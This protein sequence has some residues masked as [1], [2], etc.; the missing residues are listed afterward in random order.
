MNSRGDRRRGE[1]GIRA[2]RLLYVKCETK[3]RH[4]LKVRGLFSA[5]DYNNNNFYQGC[6]PG[7]GSHSSSPS[8]LQVYIS[9]YDLRVVHQYLVHRRIIA[10]V[11]RPRNDDYGREVA[12]DGMSDLRR[13]RVND[14][15]SY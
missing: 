15:L 8:H 1:E 2:V 12:L 4:K 5:V 13:I 3:F 6:V 14:N 10:Q 7:D 9:V 11:R